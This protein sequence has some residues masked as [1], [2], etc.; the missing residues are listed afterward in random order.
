[1]LP[2]GQS[3]PYNM[4]RDW[5]NDSYTWNTPMAP[6]T[7]S[8]AVWVRPQGTTGGATS[9]ATMSYTL[10]AP[11]CTLTSLTPT[12]A[13]PQ[14]VGTLVHLAAAANCTGGG[15]AEFKFFV[16]G[17]GESVFTQLRDWGGATFDWSSTG[18]APGDYT[19]AAWSRAVGSTA[20]QSATTAPYQLR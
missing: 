7:Y 18:R 1:V 5:G 20:N 19:F 14:N 3:P 8:L 4:L 2:P 10:V 16:K 9:V 15:T 13:S 11:T 6:G 17:P 12:P